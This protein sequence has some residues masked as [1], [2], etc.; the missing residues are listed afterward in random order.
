[1]HVFVWERIDAF[2]KAN[3]YSPSYK[4]MCEDCKIA[5]KSTLAKI[6]RDLERLGAIRRQPFK[7]RSV[8]T[9]THPKDLI[10]KK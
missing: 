7:E 9:L 10:N 5:S 3:G 4:Q 2:R 1:M 6:Y 8:E